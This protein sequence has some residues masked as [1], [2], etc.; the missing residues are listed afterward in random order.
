MFTAGS[1]TFKT[2]RGAPG[3][4]KLIQLGDFS[5]NH[6]I[7]SYGCSSQ[8]RLVPQILNLERV[9]KL[10]IIVYDLLDLLILQI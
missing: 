2:C 4:L 1:H 7:S 8:G 5:E 6:H 10:D 9:T 3:A